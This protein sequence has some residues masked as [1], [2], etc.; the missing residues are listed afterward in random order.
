MSAAL[1]EEKFLVKQ[2]KGKFDSVGAGICF[3]QII[4]CSSKGEGR[5]A[6]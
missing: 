3:E 2:N 4:N 5:V 6:G 1:L